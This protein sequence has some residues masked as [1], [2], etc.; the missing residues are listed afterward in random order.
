LKLLSNKNGLQSCLGYDFILD[1]KKGVENRVANA[2]SRR[3]GWEE[4]AT[5]SYLS[6][7]TTDWV[8][9]LKNQYQLDPELAKL[10]TKWHDNS[11]DTQKFSLKE[12]LLLYKEN[13]CWWLSPA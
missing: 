11:L 12:G 1:Y 9:N 7:P 2:L 8:A 13:S 3:E 6:I 10:F 4:E 5:L